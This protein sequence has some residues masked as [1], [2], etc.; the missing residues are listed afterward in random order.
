MSS[1]N[2]TVK[3]S[4]EMQVTLKMTTSH[5]QGEEE[6]ERSKTKPIRSQPPTTKRLLRAPSRAQGVGAT[7][8]VADPA[9]LPGAA[10]EWTS[11]PQDRCQRH[12]GPA[13][14][15]P[16]ARE[17]C[18]VKAETT[19]AGEHDSHGTQ[20]GQFETRDGPG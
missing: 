20:G 11:G 5:S 1:M 8:P 10:S 18:V 12:Q 2:T 6:W 4:T 15:Y 13:L 3:K 16:G 7:F 9:A 17:Q 19:Q 14:T